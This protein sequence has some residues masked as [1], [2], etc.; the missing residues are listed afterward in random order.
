L[1]W[2]S[3]GPIVHHIAR[4]ADPKVS[5]QGD[6]VSGSP[7]SRD[8]LTPPGE[9]LTHLSYA[10]IGANVFRSASN[11]ARLANIVPQPPKHCEYKPISMLFKY[12]DA[13]LKP[14]AIPN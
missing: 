11:F 14:Q 7:L 3:K 6:G 9:R 10:K 1:K 2:R 4:K 5:R 13:I 12:F 8:F